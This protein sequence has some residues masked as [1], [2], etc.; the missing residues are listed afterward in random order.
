M[1]AWVVNFKSARDTLFDSAMACPCTAGL[2]ALQPYCG[3]LEAYR[4]ACKAGGILPAACEFAIKLSGSLGVRDV[5]GAPR[6]PLYDA[7]QAA[8]K[9]P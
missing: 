5:F 3:L 6:A 8:R 7:L 1:H 4:G 9:L 2:P